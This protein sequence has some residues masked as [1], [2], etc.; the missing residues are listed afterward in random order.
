MNCVPLGYVF[1]SPLIFS[2]SLPEHLN[3]TT[4]RGCQHQILTSGRIPALS[5]RFFLHTEFAEA[6][7]QDIITRCQGRLDDFKQGFNDLNG[8]IS[9][10]A[11]LSCRSVQRCRFSSVPCRNSVIVMMEMKGG[12]KDTFAKIP[13]LVKGLVH[14]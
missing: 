3:V 10:K 4:R 8:F 6:G 2:L 11:K 12:D 13:I 1:H 14:T 7:N 9:G 5:F